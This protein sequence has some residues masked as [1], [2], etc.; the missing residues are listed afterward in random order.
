M[1][2][3]LEGATV[4]LYNTQIYLSEN[5]MALSEAHLEIT[6]K[7]TISLYNKQGG[8]IVQTKHN[9]QDSISSLASH[10]YTVL[11]TEL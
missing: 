2:E 8:E 3:K 10:S 7:D 9:L 11:V 1:R 4:N 5:E 6:A